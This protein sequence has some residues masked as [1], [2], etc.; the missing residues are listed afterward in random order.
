MNAGEGFGPLANSILLSFVGVALTFATAWFW[1]AKNE[2]VEK[3]RVIAV[4]HEAVK[5]R[6]ANAE[7][8]LARIDQVVV[9]INTMMQAMLVRELTHEHKPEMDGLMQKLGPPNSLTEQENA[10]LLELLDER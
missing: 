5:A 3:A 6:L 8:Q 2:A 10:R 4:D 9:P 7:A 1:F